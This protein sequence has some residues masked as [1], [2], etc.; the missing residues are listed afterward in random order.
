[1]EFE[2]DP[3]KAAA[4]AKKHGVDF[5]EAMTMFADPLELTIAD[6]DH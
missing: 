3:E 6:P 5:S 1:M 2:W 4:N